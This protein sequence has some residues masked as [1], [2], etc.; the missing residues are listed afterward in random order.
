MGRRTK[1]TFLLDR[2]PVRRFFVLRSGVEGKAM[3]ANARSWA[4][5]LRAVSG[6]VLGAV[7]GAVFAATL[8]I[9]SAA[10]DD[11]QTCAYASGDEAI[12]AC[13]RAIDSGSL[14][15]RGLA[16]M[17]LGRALQYSYKRDSDRAI[18]DLN[19]AIRIDPKDATAYLAAP[20]T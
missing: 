5:G 14:S 17:Y 8:M 11:V 15:G 3:F 7:L 2:F 20:H 10:A 16:E 6:A 9:G 18:A 13:S 1:L 4:P 19:E 12:A